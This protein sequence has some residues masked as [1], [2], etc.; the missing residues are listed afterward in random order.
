M[1]HFLMTNHPNFLHR[2]V[3]SGGRLI[4]ARL[5]EAQLIEAWLIEA[6]LIDLS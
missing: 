3:I 2:P 5:T 6:R 1:T 4:E